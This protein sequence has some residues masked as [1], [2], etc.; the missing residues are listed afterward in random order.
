VDKKMRSDGRWQARYLDKNGQLRS[1]YGRT[2]E[3]AQMKALEYMLGKKTPKRRKTQKPP[4]PTLKEWIEQ[5]YK[6]YKAP[7]IGE[8]WAKSINYNLNKYI[9][10]VL[11]D[12]K[13][14]Q[15]T[16]IDLQTLINSIPYKRAK[17]I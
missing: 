3:E 9:L 8:S 11:G 12:K 6:L 1:V 5:W 16:L 13:I 4:I 10:P 15:I 17:M 2:Q 7:Y 14:N